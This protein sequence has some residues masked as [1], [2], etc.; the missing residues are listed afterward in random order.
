MLTGKNYA[1]KILESGRYVNSNR[2]LKRIAKREGYILEDGY[3]EGTI[4]LHPSNRRVVTVIPN[5]KTINC[6]DTIKSILEALATGESSFRRKP[7]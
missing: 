1:K 2:E 7:A 5:H 3:R 6:R 4:V